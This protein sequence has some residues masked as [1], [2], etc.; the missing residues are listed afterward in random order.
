VKSRLQDPV[1][2]DEHDHGQEH[3]RVHGLADR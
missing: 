3:Q 2:D 1:V